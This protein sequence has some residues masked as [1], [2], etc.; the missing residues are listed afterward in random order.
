MSDLHR[1]AVLA[2]SFRRL[3]ELAAT[4]RI[5]AAALLR[6]CAIAPETLTQAGARMPL[7]NATRMLHLG[8]ARSGR[9]DFGLQLG[10]LHQPGDLGALGYLWLS[11]PDIG[12]AMAAG[13][14]YESFVQGGAAFSYG[15]HGDTLAVTYVTPN[16][17][18][19]L[20]PQDAEFTFALL[21]TALRRL[22]MRH[23]AA[24]TI[25]FAHAPDA[26]LAAYR[27][28]FGVAPQFNAAL[29]RMT[30]PADTAAL[31]I[32]TRDAGLFAILSDYI[33][34]QSL[35][36]AHAADLAA[37]VDRAI[38]AS[39]PSG[40]VTLASLAA[41]L[42]LSPRSLQRRLAASGQSVRGLLA[43]TRATL[44][45]EALALPAVSVDEAARRLG[46]AD[47]SA[48]TR[49]FHGWHGLSPRAW[50]R[51]RALD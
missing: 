3:P 1:A 18:A 45:L 41:S 40:Q 10:M 17:P 26:K 15:L 19:A 32:P 29:N 36:L 34:R 14:R 47:P 9:G 27:H 50:R 22:S 7:V 33:E 2:G 44:A 6:D 38:R 30:L 35:D 23:V 5:P 46:F 25:E 39:L 48:F 42:R 24:Q 20:R 13:A 12:T 4:L 43:T 28:C 51:G 37:R 21:I 16:L 49:A 8:A 11:A 31:A